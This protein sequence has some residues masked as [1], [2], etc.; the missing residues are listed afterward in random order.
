MT[1]PSRGRVSRWE[2][3]VV[4]L[5]SAAVALAVWAPALLP[6]RALFHDMLLRLF[7]PNFE[8]TAA[9][10]RSGHFPFWNPFLYGGAPFMANFQSALFY[11]VTWFSV[12]GNFPAQVGWDAW[13]HAVLAAV[14]FYHWARWE[15]LSRH[16]AAAAALVGAFNGTFLLHHAYPG[17]FHAI[18]LAPL[19]FHGARRLAVGPSAAGWALLAAG[20][21]L[22]VFAGHPQFVVYTCLAVLALTA[23]AGAA[24]WARVAG[25]LT[26]GALL[27]AVQWLPSL[28]VLAAIPRSAGGG[29]GTAWATMYSLPPAEAL[30]MLFQ[31]VWSL[32][33]AP[34]SGDPN[35]LGFY[36]GIPA[37]V[38]AV[39]GAWKVR[40]AAPFAGLTAAAGVLALGRYLP[41]YT[42]LLDHFHFL[43]LFR[44]PAQ[45]LFLAGIGCAM[46]TG[47]GLDRLSAPRTKLFL[48]VLV[49]IDLWAFGI[50]ALNTVDARVYTEMPATARFLLLENPGRVMTAPKTRFH[51]DWAGAD[52]TAAWGSFKEALIPHVGMAWGLRD[53]DGNEVVHFA[54]YEKILAEIGASPRSP[55]LDWMG[56]RHVLSLEPV[57]GA[58]FKEVFRSSV[59]VYE[60]DQAVPRVY[61]PGRAV[62]ADRE[63][64]FK[65]IAGEP[66]PAGGTLFLEGP[67]SEAELATSSAVVAWE[68]VGPNRL[69]LSVDAAGPAWVTVTDAWAPGWTA[70]VDG[71]PTP[72]LRANFFQRALKV[73]AGASSAELRYSPPGLAWGVFLSFMGVALFVAGLRR[74]G[75]AGKP[76]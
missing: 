42:W 59:G 32:S 65:R 41:G 45:D 76:I 53:A 14:S 11:P 50:H 73:P 3:A 56:V 16:G 6:G 20:A 33:W 8:F 70:R 35:I 38:L 12:L 15:G 30:R 37:L 4:A 55:W 75:G 49:G 66:R 60:N 47:M 48:T 24:G 36:V 5:L 13:A 10:F 58:G 74:F 39:V 7:H 40:R 67:V 44:F 63:E 28:P 51:L 2:T 43:K 23:G 18:A 1:D 29:L 46:L 61:V 17:N 52:E 64:A 72:L 9:A 69:K 71:R 62:R 57:P 54:D 26:A 27:S 19:L 31:P 22:Q 68:D 34:A 25:A 21:A